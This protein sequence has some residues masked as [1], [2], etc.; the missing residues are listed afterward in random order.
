MANA[1]ADWDLFQSLHAVLQAGSFSG[2]ARA[3]GLTQPTLGRHIEALEQKL[4]GALFLR[5]PRGLQATELALALAP[6]LEDMAAS[7]GAALR[8]AAGPADGSA[9]CVRLTVSEILAVEVLPP[10][11]GEF[12][13][14]HPN[15]EVELVVS[16]E[17]EDLLR[18]EADIAIRMARPTQSALVARR[19]G[20]LHFGF[21]AAPSY[22]QRRGLPA[23]LDEL[24]DKHVLIGFDRT[25]PKSIVDKVDVGRPISRDLFRF[26]TDNQVAQLAAVRAG[27]GVG[28]VQHGIA[29]RDGLTAVL[30]DKFAFDLEVWICM[31]ES[32]KANRR[33]RLMSDHLA[34]RL[35]ALV[36][37]SQP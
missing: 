12:M 13:E 4:G 10:I 1:A 32:L 26:K 31:H 6:H 29:R 30:P 22:V 25:D 9:G 19:I 7:V 8:D 16:N 21:Y 37:E 2:A 36:A 5:S 28:A 20:A 18:R 11:L 24:A 3:R 15:V 17:I 23:D 34:D 27:L 33:M 35:K 14:Q